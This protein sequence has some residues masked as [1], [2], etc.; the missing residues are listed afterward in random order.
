V[1]KL[2]QVR[3]TLEVN[4]GGLLFPSFSTRVEVANECRVID[5]RKR[6][7]LV[8]SIDSQ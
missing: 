7:G 1:K 6:K 5:G 4:F 8:A 3:V 2:R